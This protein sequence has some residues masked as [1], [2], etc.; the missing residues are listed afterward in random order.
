[1]QIIKAVMIFEVETPRRLQNDSFR[2][3]MHM[4]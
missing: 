4:L 2:K 1:M 3:S